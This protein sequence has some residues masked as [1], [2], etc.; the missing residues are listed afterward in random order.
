MLRQ[1]RGGDGHPTTRA[2]L[3]LPIRVRRRAPL[4]TRVVAYEINVTSPRDA[5]AARLG[6]VLL[7]DELW[8]RFRLAG[9]GYSFGVTPVVTRWIEALLIAVPAHDPSI[10]L[11]PYLDQAIAQVREGTYDDRQLASA[12][13]VA[14][15]ELAAEDRSPEALAVALSG[16]GAAWHNARVAAELSSLE[17]PGLSKIL[18]DWMEK[19]R[20]LFVYV[21]PSP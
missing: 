16:G 5:A 11:S 12:R 20:S 13:A 18:L 15:T 6:A 4:E 17:R 3:V 1:F 10:D 2:K 7:Q 8:R 9:V 19:E 14:M 21:G